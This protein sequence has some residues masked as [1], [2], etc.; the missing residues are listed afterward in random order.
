MGDVVLTDDE[1][2]ALMAA[3]DPRG[4][5]DGCCAYVNPES[6][7]EDG[8][9]RDCPEAAA[10]RARTLVRVPVCL[11]TNDSVRALCVEVRRLRAIIEGRTTPPTPAEM[12]SHWRAGGW[13]LVLGADGQVRSL[14][15]RKDGDVFRGARRIIAVD[16]DGR[17]CA[18]PVA[19]VSRG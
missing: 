18:W 11:T 7:T 3:H 4:Y 19:E 5:C 17:P 9:H 2:R 1:V 10:L 15:V 13:W 6:I 16:R 8:Y 12:L 14:C